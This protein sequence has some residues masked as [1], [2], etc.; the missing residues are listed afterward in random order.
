MGTHAEGSTASSKMVN[1]GGGASVNSESETEPVSRG[2]SEEWGQ[3]SPGG[4]DSDERG[5]GKSALVLLDISVSAGG[6][7]AAAITLWFS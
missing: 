4:G 6:L 5:G 2:Q 7:L 3:R 1:P